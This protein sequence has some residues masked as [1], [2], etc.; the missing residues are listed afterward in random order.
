MLFRSRLLKAGG[1]VAFAP[2]VVG[3]TDVPRTRIDVTGIGRDGVAPIARDLS[4]SVTADEGPP[5]SDEVST[6]IPIRMPRVGVVR[7]YLHHLLVSEKVLLLLMHEYLRHSQM[8]HANFRHRTREPLHAT[9]FASNQ[10]K[11]FS[12]H[13]P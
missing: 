1:R 7:V 12:T 9:Q 5:V 13:H 2:P 6:S 3:T 10:L 8:L 11:E 4:L